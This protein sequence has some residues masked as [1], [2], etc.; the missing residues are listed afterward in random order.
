MA[1]EKRVD[2][3]KALVGV[4][5]GTV[6]EKVRGKMVEGLAKMVLER[7]E[8]EGKGVVVR[9]GSNGK[10]EGEGEGEGKGDRKGGGGKVTPVGGTGSGPG[11]LRN[12]QRLRDEIYLE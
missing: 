5:K 10:A 7:R 9:G 2:E 1:A 6:E 3:L 12:L 8:E 4:W 11:F